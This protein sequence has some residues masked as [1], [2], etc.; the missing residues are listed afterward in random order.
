MVNISVLSRL[1]AAV[2]IVIAIFYTTDYFVLSPL[3]VGISVLT[4]GFSPEGSSTSWPNLLSNPF[5]LSTI[6]DRYFEKAG[7]NN[8]LS[9]DLFNSPKDVI[10]WAPSDFAITHM[11]TETFNFTPISMTEDLFLSKV[12]AQSMRPSKIIPFFYRAS[13]EFDKEDITLTT[14]VTSNRFKVFAQLVENYQG[15]FLSVQHSHTY[16]VAIFLTG[17]I[18]VTIH[19]KS[20]PADLETLF[21]SLHILYTSSPSMSTYV[22]V[23]LV[24]D[25]FDRQFNTWRNIARLFARTD[26]VMMLDVDFAVCTDFRRGVRES[27]AV[28]NKLKDGASAFVIPAFEYA[29]FEDGIDQATFPR[30]KQVC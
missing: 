3:H 19:V 17:P 4:T 18:S 15:R 10:K 29:K 12:F 11:G 5:T 30:D 9:Q 8:H 20:T 25:S 23:H 22:D 14:L 16:H 21:A 13:G 6:A 26:F 2:Y 27:Q 7:S 1:T 28:M 24:V